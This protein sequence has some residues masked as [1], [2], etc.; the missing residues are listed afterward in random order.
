[1][2]ARRIISQVA[3]ASRAFRLPGKIVVDR[4]ALLAQPR[5][6][7]SFGTSLR[8]SATASDSSFEADPAVK[9]QEWFDEGNAKWNDEDVLGALDCYE[10]SA[11]SKPSG[12]AYYNIGNCQHLLGKP[13]A[14]IESWKKAL[15]LS[16]TLA[17]AYVNIA[18]VYALQLRDFDSAVTNLEEA[19]KLAPNDGEVRYNF[20]V[21][22]DA[23]GNLERAVEQYRLAIRNGVEQA[24][25]NLRNAGARLLAQEAKRAE[26]EGKAGTKEEKN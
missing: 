15:E 26:E 14:A 25:K 16:P 6:V 13:E 12:E 8:C 22:L 18:N 19:L 10:K 2:L 5:P 20:G 9:A 1:M 21:I 17:E 4:A 11:W 3:A 23:M 7:R 24:E